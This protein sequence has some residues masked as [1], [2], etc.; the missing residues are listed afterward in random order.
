MTHRVDYD[1][2]APTFDAR[3]SGG[4]YRDLLRK[5]RSKILA[6]NPAYTLEVG[7][8]TG[9]WLFGLGD[10]LPHV[11]GV[12]Y[13]LQMLRQARGRDPNI[14]VSVDIAMMSVHAIV[15]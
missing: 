4:G 2:I 10:L 8:G 1:K 5:M 3:Y 15:A 14:Q 12:D 7:C 11:Y 9:Y 6:A 13:S